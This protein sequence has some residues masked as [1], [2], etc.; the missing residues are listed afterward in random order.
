MDTKA[1]ENKIFIPNVYTIV[2]KIG[3]DRSVWT[4]NW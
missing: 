1:E 2:I 3:L 4:R